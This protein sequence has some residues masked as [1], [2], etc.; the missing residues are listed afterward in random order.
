METIRR[1]LTDIAK[2]LLDIAHRLSRV[3]GMIRETEIISQQVNV[4]EQTRPNALPDAIY[5]GTELKRRVD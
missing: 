5:L 1:E 4:I 2:D 3:Q